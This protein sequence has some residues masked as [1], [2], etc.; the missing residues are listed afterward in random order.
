MNGSWYVAESFFGDAAR[1]GGTSPLLLSLFVTRVVVQSAWSFRYW[2]RLSLPG[3]PF[4]SVHFVA[5]ATCCEARI[6][7]HSVGATTPTRFPFTTICAFG[8]RDLSNVPAD[9]RVEPSVFG[10]RKST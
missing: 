7:S 5:P 2:N 6:A 9:T 4:Q 10:D 1:A 3:N 8:K